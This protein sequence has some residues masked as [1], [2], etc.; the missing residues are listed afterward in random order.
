MIPATF[1]IIPLRRAG[2]VLARLESGCGLQALLDPAVALPFPGGALERVRLDADPAAFPAADAGRL[3]RLA[4]RLLRPGGVLEWTEAAPVGPAAWSADDLAW[5]CGFER[6]PLGEAVAAAAPMAPL[7]RRRVPAHAEPP[8]PLVS[9]VIPAYKA[10]HF[11]EALA[12]ALDQDY[13]RLEILVCDDSPDDRIK[14]IVDG[15]AGMRHKVRYLRNPGTLGGRANY[16]KGFREAWGDYVKFLNDDDVLAPDCVTSLARLLRDVPGA[17][18]ATSARRLIDAAG[19]VLPAEPHTEP[20]A[21][22]DTVLA[23]EDLIGAV[24]ASGCNRIGE[25]TTVLFRK[26]DLEGARPHLMSYWGRPALRN[27]DMSVWTALLSRGDAVVAARPLSDFRTHAEQVSRDP[28]FR[29]EAV[30]AW[31]LLREDA[32]ATGLDRA[33]A[34]RG[35]GVAVECP[36]V[37][38]REAQRHLAAGAAAE[39]ETCARRAARLAPLETEPRLALARAA[40]AAGRPGQALLGLAYAHD[41]LAR[42]S[43]AALLA[44]MLEAA[45]Q[46]TAARRARLQA[47]EAIPSPS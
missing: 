19:N 22:R 16:L 36:A 27:G 46:T 5:T 28:A 12:S 35:G 23:G 6:T 26:A 32:R 4:R 40:W 43:L 29:A 38:L 3:L 20:L 7:R 1:R 10:A 8:C 9:I 13:P 47:A 14:T 37:A 44:D 15:F 41:A 17:T 33:A 45:G 24:L 42:P 2:H 34:Q 30:A 39:A 11:R 31:D 21:A 18:L 25:P